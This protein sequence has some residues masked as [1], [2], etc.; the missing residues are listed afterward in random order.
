MEFKSVMWNKQ[1]MEID[2]QEKLLRIESER[3]IKLIEQ[4][5]SKLLVGLKIETSKVNNGAIEKIEFVDG[6][7]FKNR[8][9]N[10]VFW[11]LDLPEIEE[12][13]HSLKT[14]GDFLAEED[15][16]LIS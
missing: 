14:E 16:Y 6:S 15:V 7:S 4:K 10:S 11:F 3:V 9:G 12:M 1:T 8:N 13:Y 2:I 5:I